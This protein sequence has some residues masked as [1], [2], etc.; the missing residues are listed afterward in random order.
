MQAEKSTAQAY[1]LGQQHLLKQGQMLY[2][3]TRRLL[4]DVGITAGMQV[5][6]VGCGP[7]DVS[8][9]A[10]ELVGEMGSVV[11]VDTN[12]S[13]LQLAQARAQVADLSNVSFLAGD[14][15]DLPLDQEYDAIVGRLILMHLRKPV[16]LV[17]LLSKHL[18]PGGVMA[19][20]DYDPSSLAE[21]SY[22]PCP[23]WE[24]AARWIIQAFRQAGIELQMGM[25][26]HSTFL[27]AGL[28]APQLRYEA[29]MGAGP[30]W[31]GYD[32]MAQTVHAALPLILKFGFATA[33]EVG[34]DTLAD[35]L[36]EEI[37]SQGGVARF[38]ALVSAWVRSQ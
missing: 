2:P 11:G 26:Y 29:A 4:E 12:A 15:H 1:V 18:R 6:D 10:A 9:I 8:L 23:L 31:V 34:I 37:V 5:L 14:I 32:V 22:P 19:F 27:A 17:R 38:P 33:E 28:P 20:Q 24:Q 36:R 25:K 13:V 16:A 7:G 30:D 35:R 3:F 21:A